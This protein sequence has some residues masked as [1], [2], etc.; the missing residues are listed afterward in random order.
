ME[1]S[2]R[3]L[4]VGVG[5]NSQVG[6]IMSLLGAT[7]EDSK[8]KKADKK[9]TKKT[10]NSKTTK[11]KPLSSTKVSPDKSRPNDNESNNQA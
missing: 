3:M 10:E 4:V 9:T 2:G 6:R 1:G 11:P 5:L 8:K 7:D